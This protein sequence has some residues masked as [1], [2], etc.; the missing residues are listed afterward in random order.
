MPHAVFQEACAYKDPAP[1]TPTTPDLATTTKS[2]AATT[3]STTTS[4]ISTSPSSPSSSSPPLT[5]FHLFPHLYPELR[6]KIW[7]MAL[8]L[9]PR[10]VTIHYEPSTHSFRTPTPPPSLLHTNRESRHEAQRAYPLLFGTASAPSHIPFH[11]AHDTLYFPRRSTMGYDDSLRD[12]GA[13]MATPA[14]LDRVR[15][16]ALD[17]VDCREKRPWEAYDKA[18][19][20]KSFPRL[21]NV[22]LVRGPKRA[23]LS[24]I[25]RAMGPVVEEREVEFVGVEE[26]ERG[27]VVKGFEAAFF[28]E[29][30]VLERIHCERGEEYV[31]ARLPPVLVVSKRRVER[32]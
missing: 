13:L 10:I 2:P 20:V 17:S 21:E 15:V 9:G 8:D 28:G 19:F 5:S 27:E 22:V 14:D 23:W 11:P 25:P 3:T 18:V 24:N 4:A 6:L 31:V 29:E 1:L 12:F 32:D 7:H 26:E 30:E 16:V